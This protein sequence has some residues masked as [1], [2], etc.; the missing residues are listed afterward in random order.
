M[1][2]FTFHTAATAPAAAQPILEQ[3]TEKY[4]F[5]PNLMA[6]LANASATLEA[7]VALTA[8]MEKTSFSPTER[9]VIVLTA[10]VANGC[11][12]CVASHSASAAR[13]G[14]PNHVIDAIRAGTTIRD[15]LCNLTSGNLIGACAS[16]PTEGHSPR[17]GSPLFWYSMKE[18]NQ[19]WRTKYAARTGY[20]H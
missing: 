14:I 10:S 2:G 11:C 8:L 15:R 18:T 13:Q 5:T 4:G 6:G 1:T 17:W 7:Y 9:Q 16:S 19:P 3:V 20:G 12:Y